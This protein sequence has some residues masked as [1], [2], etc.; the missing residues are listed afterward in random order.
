MRLKKTFYNNFT[1]VN[2]DPNNNV[3][4]LNNLNNIDFYDNFGNNNFLE[5]S[6]LSN[7]IMKN[8]KNLVMLSKLNLNLNINGNKIIEMN[9]LEDN[10]NS[11]SSLSITSK[12]EKKDE[13]INGFNLN[14]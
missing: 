12:K 13:L 11:K 5:K 7:S 1:E 3:S 14:K 4:N 9:F 8:N 6:N 10:S 2:I